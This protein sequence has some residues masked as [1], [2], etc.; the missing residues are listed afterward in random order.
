MVAMQDINNLRTNCSSQ[1]ELNKLDE[2]YAIIQSKLVEPVMSNLLSTL[3]TAAK[4]RNTNLTK[5]D[6]ERMIICFFDE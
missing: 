2:D 3:T 1:L 5:K 4:K 6:I